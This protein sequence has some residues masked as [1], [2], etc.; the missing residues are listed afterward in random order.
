[1]EIRDGKGP[2]ES[3]A[4]LL[5]SREMAVGEDRCTIECEQG[6]KQA[7]PERRSSVRRRGRKIEKIK[8]L[9]IAPKLGHG[10]DSGLGAGVVNFKMRFD[11]AQPAHRS[12]ADGGEMRRVSFVHPSK[13]STKVKVCLSTLARDEHAK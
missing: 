10:G 11:S 8:P 13:I 9:A 6:F 3:G 5:E 12:Q 1:M 2:T 4:P 7:E